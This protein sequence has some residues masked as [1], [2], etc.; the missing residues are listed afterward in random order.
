MNL[1]QLY[2][3]KTVCKYSNIT[4][5]AK[6]LH[7]SQPAVTKAVRE[8]EDEL[9]VTLLS[10]SNK[11]VTPTAEGEMFLRRSN[12]I[13]SDLGSLIDEM[14]DLGQRR[15]TRVRIGISP[16]LSLLTLP[17]L[18]VLA[19]DQFGVNLEIH[20]LDANAS[21]R[22]VGNDELDL[23]MALLDDSAY[24]SIE[25]HTLRRSSLQFCTNLSHPLAGEP[26][27]SI[28]RLE[29]QPMVSFLPGCLPQ[30]LAERYSIA[31]NYI[32]STNQLT[33]L[34]RY[35]YSGLASTLHIPEPFQN[36]P[37]IATIPLDPP[38]PLS[39][40]IIKKKGKRLFHGAHQLYT[41]VGAHPEAV[42][43]PASVP[44]PTL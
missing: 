8:L 19:R 29:S 17:Q 21:I 40:A 26:S 25:F 11:N 39:I 24:P 20:D 32:L 5:A 10:R 23:S 4:R 13:L 33:T 1:S 30:R 14:Q 43:N 3:Y 31:S 35:I 2:Y 38:V 42:L 12:A 18:Y 15:K 36:D 37:A 27:V 22:A 28:S 6:E 9:G 41:Y 34:Q 16:A 7:I 44:A